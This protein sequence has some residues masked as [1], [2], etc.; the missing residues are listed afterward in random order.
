METLALPA[1]PLF[2]PSCGGGLELDLLG[3]DLYSDPFSLQDLGLG[4]FSFSP[5]VRAPPPQ[6]AAPGLARA[7][8]KAPSVSSPSRPRPRRAQR[9]PQSPR[10]VS[11]GR[12]AACG[13]PFPRATLRLGRGLTPPPRRAP[14][15][16]LHALPWAVQPPRT[17]RRVMAAAGGAHSVVGT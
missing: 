17:G 13:H 16:A 4:D 15:W 10:R 1:A 11:D 6:R 7:P 5:A 2:R 9:P 14:R 8:R 3:P 12:L